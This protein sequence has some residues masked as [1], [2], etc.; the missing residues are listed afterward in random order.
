M[1]AYSLIDAR[2]WIIIFLILI[3]KP[4]PSIIFISKY[5]KIIV[6]S[7]LRT[8]IIVALRTFK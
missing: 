5:K 3:L 2:L 7:K 4:I 1:A 6:I 8:Y